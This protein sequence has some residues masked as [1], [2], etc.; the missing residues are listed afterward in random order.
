MAV[1]AGHSLRVHC[2]RGG[3]AGPMACPT[4]SE[5]FTVLYS[6]GRMTR[7]G[8]AEVVEKPPFLRPW[9]GCCLPCRDRGWAVHVPAPVGLRRRGPSSSRGRARRDPG[10][11][12]G[13][14]RSCGPRP[15]A[16][17]NNNAACAPDFR[18]ACHGG[19]FFG[20]FAEFRELTAWPGLARCRSGPG[21]RGVAPRGRRAI[22]RLDGGP[23]GPKPT[24]PAGGH[25]VAPRAL[26]VAGRIRWL[27]ARQCVPRGPFFHETLPFRHS[28][29][30][31]F[32]VRRAQIQAC[33]RARPAAGPCA[34]A[35][36]TRSA[37]VP[38]ARGARWAILVANRS[39]T[40]SVVVCVASPPRA[41]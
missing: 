31:L 4:M 37:H 17:N 7:S 9:H 1:A 2:G 13:D 38:P 15:D 27:A 26:E 35:R 5:I 19:S 36:C 18:P 40:I 32:F 16:P 12:P 33:V 23:P 21:S 10:C 11:V 6:P 8:R 29:I 22:G 28:P 30:D 3:S 20:L 34:G 14:E 39:G 24:N 41:R 25:G